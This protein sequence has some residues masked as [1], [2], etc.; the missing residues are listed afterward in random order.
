GFFLEAR[1]D[2]GVQNPQ[3]RIE[4]RPGRGRPFGFER[5]HGGASDKHRIESD[6]LKARNTGQHLAA[7]AARAEKTE[8]CIA[9]RSLVRNTKRIDISR[10]TDE[11]WRPLLWNA[12]VTT[13]LEKTPKRTR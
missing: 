5:P 12:I 1:I 7:N 11:R 2:L 13:G 4:P 9:L 6:A 10:R 8:R 3:A